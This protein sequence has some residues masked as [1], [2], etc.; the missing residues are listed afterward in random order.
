M[1]CPPKKVPV[2]ERTAVSGVLCALMKYGFS[3]PEGIV[4]IIY[5]RKPP[6]NIKANLQR[7]ILWQL[8]FL[9]TVTTIEMKRRSTGQ[10]SWSADLGVPSAI[11]FS[12]QFRILK[13]IILSNINSIY[14]AAWCPGHPC[15]NFLDPPLSELRLTLTSTARRNLDITYLIIQSP[16]WRVIF[17]APVIV[18]YI[19]LDITKPC[20]ISYS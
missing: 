5:F 7:N 3:F 19:C 14:I 20:Y 9:K 10:V 6:L 8:V 17:F 4:L 2:V 11:P 18:K 15:L 16:R 13:S 1:D 12:V